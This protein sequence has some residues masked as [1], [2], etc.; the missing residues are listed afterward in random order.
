MV[1]EM[2]PPYVF[3]LCGPVIEE[4]QDS[5]LSF[6]HVSVKELVRWFSMTK[7]LTNSF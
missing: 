5:T 4:R 1:D 7:L 6:I 3:D 2:V